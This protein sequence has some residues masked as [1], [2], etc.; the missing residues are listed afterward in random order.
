MNFKRHLV[1]M[2]SPMTPKKLYD[3]WVDTVGGGKHGHPHF[4]NLD[5]KDRFQYARMHAALAAA[6]AAPAADEF[7]PPPDKPG[8]NG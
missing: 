8:G 7:P 4:D 5:D 2:E 3:L 6:Y 1:T